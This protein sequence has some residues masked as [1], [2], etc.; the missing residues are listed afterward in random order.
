MSFVLRVREPLGERSAR[1]NELPLAVG[2]E[3]ATVA[4]PGIKEGVI[5]ARIGAD[6]HG[7]YVEAPEDA[8]G[9]AAVDGRTVRERGRIAHGDVITVGGARI[10]CRVDGSEAL[11]DVVHLEGNATQPPIFDSTER[12]DELLSA[13]H[14]RRGG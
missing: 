5:A 6:E 4:V 2:G 7:L 1:P 10:H 11:L 9:L 12:E 3:G 14:D 13:W 8:T